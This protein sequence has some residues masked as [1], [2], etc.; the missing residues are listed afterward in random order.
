MLATAFVQILQYWQRCSTTAICE[1]HTRPGQ[2][3]QETFLGAAT[4][5]LLKIIFAPVMGILAI[6]RLGWAAE[7][8]IDA[9]YEVVCT[10]VARDAGLGEIGRM[11]LLMTPR[12]GPRVR[13]AVVTTDLPLV[14][15][16]PTS[17]P[18]VLD[19][20]DVCRKCADICPAHAVP[21][22]APAGTPGGRTR[23]PG[24]IS[25]NRGRPS[26]VGV[27]LSASVS[28]AGRGTVRRFL[29]G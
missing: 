12:L 20:C 29:G 13:L 6:R 8:H 4:I 11:G 19:F 28:S 14:A 17:D 1:Q 23:L 27:A 22:G 2:L 7:A 21:A 24:R 16:V 18:T 10:L 3:D 9:H 5:C 26:S 25:G 15:D